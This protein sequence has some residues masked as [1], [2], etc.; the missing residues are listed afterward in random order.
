MVSCARCAR[1]RIRPRPIGLAA[2]DALVKRHRDAGLDVEVR[3]TGS[4]RPLGPA[5]DQAAY[6]ILQ[7]SLTNAL[8]HG[9]GEATVALAS[10]ASALEIGVTNPTV[11][12][13][14][15]VGHGI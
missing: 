8:R 14:G 1:T 13:V 4:R 10:G 3:V 5:V 2:F 15:A 9:S 7:E 12:G 6:R 11:D